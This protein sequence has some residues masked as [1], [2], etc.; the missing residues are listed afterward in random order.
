M[1]KIT[2][3][4]VCMITAMILIATCIIVTGHSVR[5][6]KI[7]IHQSKV[8]SCYKGYDLNRNT[9]EIFL[10]VDYCAGE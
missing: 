9:G 7:N 3:E 2:N 5:Q 4:T 1:E 10:S 6:M 8:E